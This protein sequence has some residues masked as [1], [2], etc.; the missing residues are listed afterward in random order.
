MK[1]LLITGANGGIGEAV[2]N[3]LGER[4]EIFV[5]G[6]NESKIKELCTKYKFIKGSCPFLLW[7]VQ[8][9]IITN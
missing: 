5:L 9:N 3:L 8:K 7:K 6:R 2:C 4:Y 1:K